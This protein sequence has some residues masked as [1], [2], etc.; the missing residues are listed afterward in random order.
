MAMLVAFGC[1]GDSTADPEQVTPTIVEATMVDEGV[2]VTYS[3]PG[4]DG[5][6]WPVL[7]ISVRETGSSLPA[8]S[9]FVRSVEEEGTVLIPIE[10]EPNRELTIYGSIFYEDGERVYLDDTH[11]RS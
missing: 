1:G 2:E 4:A 8:R 11:I 9:E 7:R 5:G 3:A 10:V 6:E